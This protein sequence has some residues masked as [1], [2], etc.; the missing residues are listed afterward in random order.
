MVLLGFGRRLRQVFK[1]S[2]LLLINGTLHRPYRGLGLGMPRACQRF[3]IW[4]F[5][6]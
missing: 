6:E 4:T 5:K 2:C 1:R 3:G